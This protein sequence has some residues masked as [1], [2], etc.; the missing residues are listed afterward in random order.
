[1][2]LQKSYQKLKMKDINKKLHMLVFFLLFSSFLRHAPHA[3]R[4]AILFFI[5][6][7]EIFLNLLGN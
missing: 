5:H 7:K 1:M 4:H 6:P 3:L 2:T